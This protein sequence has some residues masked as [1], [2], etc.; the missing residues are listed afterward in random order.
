MLAIKRYQGEVS[1]NKSEIYQIMQ[2]IIEVEN[3]INFLLGR[4]PQTIRR[5]SGGFL[6]FKPQMIPTGIPSQLLQN[7]IGSNSRKT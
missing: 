4:T 2:E 3:R 6:Q 5:S 1:K 7:R